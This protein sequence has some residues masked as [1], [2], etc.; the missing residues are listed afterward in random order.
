MRVPSGQSTGRTELPSAAVLSDF[1]KLADSPPVF[2][3]D[4]VIFRW[5]RNARI[6]RLIPVLNEVRILE[7]H[8]IANNCKSCRKPMEVDRS[9]INVAK[10]AL[11]ECSE[12]VALLVKQAA[13]VVK[14]KVTYQ[15]PSGGLKEVVK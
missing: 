10:R 12:E 11:A 13:G 4:S 3:T 9:S 8:L 6:V 1:P 2:V 7:R 5:A 14:Y 15:S